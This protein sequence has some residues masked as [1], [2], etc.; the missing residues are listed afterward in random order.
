MNGLLARSLSRRLIA[1]ATTSLPTP[2]W[3]VTR[4]VVLFFRAVGSS[5][6]ADRDLGS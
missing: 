5:A 2:D 4:T 3:P 6:S 1:R